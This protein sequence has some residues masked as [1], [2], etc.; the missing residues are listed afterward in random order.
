MAALVSLSMLCM[1]RDV[2]PVV[3]FFRSHPDFVEDSAL[4]SLSNLGGQWFI[5]LL[6]QE[7]GALAF[8]ATMNVRQM[9]SVIV[10]YAAYHHPITRW[11]VVGL[12]LVFGTLLCRG[13][14]DCFVALQSRTKGAA[15]PEGAKARGA[16]DGEARMTARCEA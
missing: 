3:A 2:V 4:L 7:F 10:S 5:F 14:S 8:A 15:L 13:L 6:L 11:Q 12:V 1:C 16:G 9:G